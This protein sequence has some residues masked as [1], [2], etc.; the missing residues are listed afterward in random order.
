MTTTLVAFYLLSRPLEP[1]FVLRSSPDAPQPADQLVQAD[2]ADQIRLVGLDTLPEV[3]Q[4]PVTGEAEL[5]VVL[6]WRA[7]QETTAN[8]SVFLHLDA[9]NGQTFATVDE[10]SPEDIPTRNWPPGLYLRNPLHLKIPAGLPPIRYDLIAGIYNWETGERL[11]IQPGGATGFC[12]GS[13]WLAAPDSRPEAG[14]PIASFGPYITLHRATLA[15]N[16][17]TLVWQ[18]GQPI[19]QNYHIFVHLLDA[20]EDVLSQADGVPYQG[21]YPLPHWQPDQLVTDTRILDLDSRATKIAIGLYD[22]A[23]GQRLPAFNAGGEALPHDSFVI[24]VRP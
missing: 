14:E 20:A 24:P 8:Y 6:Y 19:D 16:R 17:L 23:T 1:L 13:V 12:L 22:P 4:L 18:T 2:F 7:L 3:I 10:A 21:L 9:P 11:P 5:K 15:K